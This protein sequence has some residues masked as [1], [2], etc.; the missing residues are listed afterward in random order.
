MIHFFFSVFKA[1]YIIVHRKF[2]DC[3]VYKM[4]GFS[5]TIWRAREGS[6]SISM[7]LT[8]KWLRHGN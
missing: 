7:S 1:G 2:P 8:S 5:V 4:T 3:S 6:N